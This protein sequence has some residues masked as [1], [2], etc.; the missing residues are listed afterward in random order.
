MDLYMSES[1]QL[2]KDILRSALA[3]TTDI[4]SLKEL[5]HLAT[6]RS[7]SF[8]RSQDADTVF[9]AVSTNPVGQEIIFNYLLEHWD[10]IYNALSSRHAAVGRIIAASSVG[11]RSQHQI[12]QLKD[13]KK[14]GKHAKEFGAFDE[15]IENAEA[16]VDWLKKNFR[17]LT[18][19]FAKSV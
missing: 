13:L 10:E 9:T 1:V 17:K 11:I 15:A 5:M 6:D 16:K 14:N 19:Y 3:C 18:E 4:S 2:E 7:S 8:V 12:E